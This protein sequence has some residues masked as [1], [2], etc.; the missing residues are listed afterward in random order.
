MI[1]TDGMQIASF[2]PV[3]EDF[4]YGT[5]TVNTALGLHLMQSYFLFTSQW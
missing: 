1:K 5:R 2:T 4:T 3:P